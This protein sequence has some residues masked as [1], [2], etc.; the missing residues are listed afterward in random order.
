MTLLVYQLITSLLRTQNSP[1]PEILN[2]SLGALLA[3]WHL[4]IDASV[5]PTN[6]MRSLMLQEKEETLLTHASTEITSKLTKML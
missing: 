3:L 1:H 6:A 2:P 5:P 4:R